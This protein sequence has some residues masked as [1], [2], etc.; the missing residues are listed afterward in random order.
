MEYFEPVTIF[1]GNAQQKQKLLIPKKISLTFEKI[2][3][4][5]MHRIEIMNEIISLKEYLL[6]AHLSICNCVFSLLK[7]KHFKECK[8]DSIYVNE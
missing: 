1:F 6:Y 3:H 2:L 7:L 5:F 4:D 8:I